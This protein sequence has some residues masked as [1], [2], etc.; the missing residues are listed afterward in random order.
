MSRHT[1]SHLF[2]QAGLPAVALLAKPV[3]LPAQTMLLQ[4]SAR[5]ITN[6]LH[7]HLG[8]CLGVREASGK[9]PRRGS[10]NCSQRSTI[11]AL[12]A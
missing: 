9:Q 3:H 6:I 10:F 4:A 8:R 11:T 1:C 12:G 7:H 2:A 5:R